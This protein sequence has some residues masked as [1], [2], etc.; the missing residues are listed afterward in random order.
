[1]Y[2]LVKFVED[3]KLYVADVVDIKKF[4][5]DFVANKKYKVKY[6]DDHY[7]KAYIVSV[8]ATP[9]EARHNGEGKRFR[10]P[11]TRY[12]P[13]SETSTCDEQD[14]D[15][16]GVSRDNTGNTHNRT[17]TKMNLQK[18]AIA[19]Y[20]VINSNSSRVNMPDSNNHDREIHKLKLTI[21]ELKEEIVKLKEKNSEIC[22]LNVN[23]QNIV[24]EKFKDLDKA[25]TADASSQGSEGTVKSENETT[26]SARRNGDVHLGRGIWLPAHI[27]NCIYRKK[28]DT[29][30]LKEL[31]TAVF[32]DDI[33]MN[34][35]ICGMPSNRKKGEAVKPAL[36]PTKLLAIQDILNQRLKERGVSP[37]E[38][39]KIVTRMDHIINE[40]I[41]DLR[42]PP[43]S[44]K[45][46]VPKDDAVIEDET[47]LV[48]NQ[49]VI[50]FD[51]EDVP[52]TSK[53]ATE[54]TVSFALNDA[55]I[56]TTAADVHVQ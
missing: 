53:A 31:A 49:D 44:Y 34:S 5:E 45:K 26:A 27:F 10:Q 11:T 18:A 37:E 6:S 4:Q 56:S 28:K 32:G 23:L 30:F 55:I 48:L 33:L 50:I 7:Y 12:K 2:A 42:R 46:K 35:S 22:Q 16:D 52:C 41:Q 25:L 21:T 14:E 13:D 38:Q 36:D 43:R 3:G 19:N 47:E 17:K 9:D 15:L 24:I 1:M 20:Q 39:T 29:I 40:K 54:E 8:G 51:L